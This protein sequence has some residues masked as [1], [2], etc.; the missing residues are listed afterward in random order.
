MGTVTLAEH[1][2]N[3]WLIDGEEHVAG[4]LYGSLEADVAVSFVTCVSWDDL[5]AQ[6]QGSGG[7]GAQPWIINPA[8]IARLKGAADPGSI[9]FAVWSAAMDDA[10]E[11]AIETAAA[12]LAGDPARSLQLRQF[13]PQTPPPGLAD[14]QRLRYQ[15]VAAALERVGAPSERIAAEVVDAEPAAEANRMELRHVGPPAT[16]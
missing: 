12:W 10:A 2:G 7:E 11:E 5:M 4:L 6:W 13:R 15:L 14:L 16:A 8:I 9:T 3:W 1:A